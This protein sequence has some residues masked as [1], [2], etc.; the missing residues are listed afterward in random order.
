[1]KKLCSVLGALTLTVVSSTAVVACNGGID[2]SLNYTDQEKIASIYN[3]TEEQLV[4]NGVRINTLISNEDIDQVIKALELEELINKNPM[5]AMIKKSLGVYIMSNQFLNEISSKVPG[6]GWIANKLTWQSQWGLKDLV[7]SNTAKGFYNNVSGWMNHQENEWSLSVTFLDNQL[8]GWNGI[9][10]PQYVRININRKLVADENGIINQKNSNPEGIYQ[11]GS[12]H[13]SVQDPV[14]NPNNPEKGVIYQGYANSSKVFSLSNILTSQPSKIPAGFLNYSPSATDFVNNKVINLDFGNII[15]QN[16]KKE[17]EQALTKYLIE[18]PIYTSEG[19]NTNQV[20]T[21]VKNQ[22]YAIML[23]QSIDRDN[24]RDKNGR[25]LF[26][27]SEKLDAKMIVD[28]MLSSL[29]VIVNNLKTKSWTNTTLLNEFSNM[30]DSIKKSNSTFDLVSKA[31]FIQKFQ[32]VID[33]SRDRSDPNAGQ[34][35]FFVGQLNAILYKENQNSQRVLSNSQSYLDFGYDAS[36]KFKVFYWSGST[37]ITGAEDQ[38]YSPDD[39]S[40]AEDY[41]AD[42]GFRNV[43]LSLRLNQGAASYVVLDK[44]RQSLKENNFVLDIFDLK[45]TSASPSDQEVDKIMLK[46]L[47]E[48]IALD[49]KQGNVDVNHDSWRIYHIVSLVN[50]Y[51]NEK[52]KEVFG[53]DSSGNLEIHNKNVSLDYSKSKSNSND[54]SKADDD[55]AFAELYK[56]KEINFIANDFSST[57]GTILRDNIYDFGLTLMWSLTNSNYIFAGTLNIFGK[58]LDTDQELNEMNLWWK[59]SSRSIG[60]IPNIVYMPSSWGK[61]FD[62]YWKNHVSKNP[63]NPDYNAR[64]K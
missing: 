21:I 18:N 55:L 62:S 59:E 3:L 58:H 31:S 63:N 51:V 47:N 36:Y 44:Y 5:G 13:I 35:S 6:Y 4:N 32:E 61:L 25:P 11:Q 12:E 15:L 24:L 39:N 2:T 34:T 29:S 57:S 45:N 41:V 48:A 22:I 1:M 46:K 50:K 26:D 23:A 38:W 19:M 9:D 7:N 37:P 40:K 42:K 20:D 27:E 60:R 28:S 8:L 64:I 49:P 10:R 16:S 54:F 43:F 56:N 14:I 17:I 30:I 52:L 33:D 53:F